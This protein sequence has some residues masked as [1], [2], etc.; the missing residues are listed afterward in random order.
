MSAKPERQANKRKRKLVRLDLQ[1]KIVFITLFV[2]CLVLL[3]NFQLTLIGLWSLE[4]QFAGSSAAEQIIATIRQST[5][6]KFLI[7]AGMAVPLAASIGILYSFK[8]C[9]PIYRFKRYF[10]D[11]VAGRWDERCMLRR[12]DDLQDVC[13]SINEACDA[14]RSH[15]RSSH[16]LLAEVRSLLD[17]EQIPDADASTAQRMAEIRS[18]IDAEA[19]EYAQRFP[20]PTEGLAS[21]VETPVSTA[22]ATSADGATSDETTSEPA[23]E[24]QT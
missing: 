16:E 7:S 20:A 4:N 6:Q 9:G 14:F 13:R 1:L 24:A 2:T 21:P 8:F 3:M 19:A 17:G 11:L 23:L 12:D 10:L 5:V 18:R 15:A 22:P